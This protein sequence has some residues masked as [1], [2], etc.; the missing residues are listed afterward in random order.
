MFYLLPLLAWKRGVS[1]Y[2]RGGWAAVA[3][4]GEEGGD[5]H[6]E[7]LQEHETGQKQ[8]HINSIPDETTPL[9]TRLLIFY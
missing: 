8:L 4:G 6:A 5:C 9:Q 3:M 1:D 2:L 7:S